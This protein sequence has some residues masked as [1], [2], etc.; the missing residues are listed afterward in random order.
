M[1]MMNI[2]LA[3]KKKV[4]ERGRARVHTVTVTAAEAMQ[5]GGLMEWPGEDEGVYL[6]A[7]R[8]TGE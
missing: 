2:A 7:T 3:S 6:L 8:S 1:Q 4:A 5:K